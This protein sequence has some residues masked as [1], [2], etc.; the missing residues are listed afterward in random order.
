MKAM[1]KMEEGLQGSE[2]EQMEEDVKMLRQVLDNLLAFL[3]EYAMV[4]FK[5]L[6]RG[7]PLSIKHQ[8]ATG[9]KVAVQA[10]TI[11]CSRCPYVIQNC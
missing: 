10:L 1:A 7:S 2:K 11:A 9:L 3:W 8:I 4:Q 5:D 6:K